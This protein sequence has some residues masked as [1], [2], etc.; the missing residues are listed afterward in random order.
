MEN[1][2]NTA[3]WETLEELVRTDKT[4]EAEELLEALSPADTALSVSRMSEEG[5]E[6]LL[7]TIEPELAADVMELL[8]ES[9]AADILERLEPEAASQI[10]EELTETDQTEIFSHLGDR[11]AEAILAE[12]D[13]IDAE[14]IRELREYEE[15]EV[16]R[17]MGTEFVSLYAVDTIQRVIDQFKSNHELYSHFEV[18][19][20]YVLDDRNRL[21]GVVPLRALL[22]S[23]FE[24]RVGEIMIRDPRK[25]LD[26]MSVEDADREFEGHGF[27]A[28]PV[29]DSAGVMLGTVR[30]SSVEEARSRRSEEDYLKAQ[31]IV[32]G[33]ELRQFPLMLRTSRRLSWLGL[34]IVLSLLSA[35]V[36]AMY[37]DT[38]ASVIALAVFLPVISGIGGSAGY[39]AVGVSMRELTLG[40]IRPSELMRVL[41]KELL[42]GLINGVVLGCVIATAAVLWDGNPYLGLVVGIAMMV[43]NIIAVSVGG[44]LPLILTRL[45]KDPAL[46]SGPIL[47][48][49]TD[50]CGFFLALALATLLLPLLK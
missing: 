13:P 17:L 27:V 5:Q 40:L 21:V 41:S 49:I 35:S 45:D 12:M 22:L 23:G 18:Q 9:Q 2:E 24:Q 30:R 37:E 15:Y 10:V 26:S 44:A 33:E 14:S 6:Q 47:T 39:Q 31:G 1:D 11:E 36:I 29:V 19:Y 48:T 38:L 16:G 4:D 46:A 25:L 28:L 3:P 8:P 34:N 50:T 43:N 7:S 32:G 20:L 42:L